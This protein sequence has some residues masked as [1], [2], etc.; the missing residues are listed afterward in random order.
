MRQITCDEPSYG[1]K[2]LKGHTQLTPQLCTKHYGN[3]TSL[4]LIPPPLVQHFL[5]FVVIKLC[6][7]S[8]HFAM[9]SL[10][11]PINSSCGKIQDI[12]L[13]FYFYYPKPSMTIGCCHFLFVFTQYRVKNVEDKSI[14]LLQ[15]NQHTWLINFLSF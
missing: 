6:L 14:F 13:S 1:P 5:V 10:S 2:V 11:C 8:Q 15:R 12:P 7:R 4:Y 3:N 9:R